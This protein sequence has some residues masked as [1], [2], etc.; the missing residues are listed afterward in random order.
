[1]RLRKVGNQRVWLSIDNIRTH[2]VFELRHKKNDPWF[3]QMTC[4]VFPNEIR[5]HWIQV[6][7]PDTGKGYG[8]FLIN[9]LFKYKKRVIASTHA[10]ALKFFLKMGFEPSPDNE[11]EDLYHIAWY[12]QWSKSSS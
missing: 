8:R 3:A 4:S 9:Q 10:G 1:M 12:P 6:K 2:I 11:I 5:L 7:A